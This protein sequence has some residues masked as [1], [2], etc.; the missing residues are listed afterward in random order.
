MLL[1]HFMAL[2]R[3]Q[4][5]HFLMKWIAVSHRIAHHHKRF[6]K[7]FNLIP[8]KTKNTTTTTLEASLLHHFYQEL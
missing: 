8:K 2:F 7:T 4:N 5:S 1:D 6:S 3:T